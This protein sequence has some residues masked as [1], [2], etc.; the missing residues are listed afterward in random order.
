[1][2][3]EAGCEHYK[4]TVED[5]QLMVRKVDLAKSISLTVESTLLWNTA[6]YAIRH[7]QIKAIQVAGG[8]RDT[9]INSV[10]NGQIP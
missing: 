1:M 8:R 7:V 3:F 6:K 10:F 9:P 4:I 5:I 2:C